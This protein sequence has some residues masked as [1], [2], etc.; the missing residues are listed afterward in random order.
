[1]KTERENIQHSKLKSQSELTTVTLPNVVF[2]KVFG[3]K[4]EPWKL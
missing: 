4:R 2:I 3:N 1:M